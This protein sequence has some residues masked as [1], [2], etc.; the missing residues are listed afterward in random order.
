MVN[1]IFKF[2]FIFTCIIEMSMYIS[3]CQE[4]KDL[5]IKVVKPLLKTFKDVL[6]SPL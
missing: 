6:N 5:T 1:C 2:L 3:K 4:D